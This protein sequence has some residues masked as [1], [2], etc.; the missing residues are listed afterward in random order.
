MKLKPAPAHKPDTSGLND[1][2]RRLRTRKYRILGC[3]RSCT[4]NEIN[5][6]G[7]SAVQVHHWLEEGLNNFEVSERL[8]AAYDHKVSPSAVARHF[9]NH[10][11]PE[12]QFAVVSSGA[13]SASHRPVD[14][15]EL[16]VGP[17]DPEAKKVTDL[18]L[19]DALIQK[20]AETV[21]MPQVRVSAE[22]M[23]RAIEL[24]YKLTA[25]SAFQDFFTAI[26]ASMEDSMAGAE[27]A[28]EALASEEEQEQGESGAGEV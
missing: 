20:G 17:P 28:P 12:D 14:K 26:G 6:P 10:L 27:E 18:D 7:T 1:R 5:L 23:L 2:F 15:S 19:L 3:K 11:V 21:G 25:G 4:L 24:R 9:R 13:R 22:Q 8:F 16:P